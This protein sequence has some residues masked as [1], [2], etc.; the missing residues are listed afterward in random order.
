MRASVPVGEDP[1]EILA[2]LKRLVIKTIGATNAADSIA[3][4]LNHLD[5]R[6]RQLVADLKAMEIRWRK[7]RE[8]LTKIG[9][10]PQT[11][12]DLFSEDEIPDMPF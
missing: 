10:D 9:I 3:D 7:A 8:F 6:R 2:K 4:D 1:W 12:Y 5:N 11:V